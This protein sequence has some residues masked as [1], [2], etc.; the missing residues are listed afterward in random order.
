MVS[1]A[2]VM[3]LDHWNLRYLDLHPNKTHVRDAFVDACVHASTSVK[4][5]L[6]MCRIA[7]MSATQCIAASIYGTNVHISIYLSTCMRTPFCLFQRL[8]WIFANNKAYHCRMS[9][10][11]IRIRSHVTIYLSATLSYDH[12]MHACVHAACT[13][14]LRHIRVQAYARRQQV[15]GYN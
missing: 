14:P 6:D 12:Y 5:A 4:L 7:A 10:A 8:C 15:V 13:S 9:H 2:V 3:C 1:G 11:C